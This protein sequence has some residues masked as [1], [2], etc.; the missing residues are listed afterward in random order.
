MLFSV[1]L[2]C[3]VFVV[4]FSVMLCCG[5]VL[6][7]FLLCRVVLCCVCVV[8]IYVS[9]Y[10][11]A[12]GLYHVHSHRNKLYRVCFIIKDVC[13]ALFTRSGHE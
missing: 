5:V 11:H 13:T 1:V 9:T 4:L 3:V 12:H 7:Y 2:C 8:F 10:I 6:C